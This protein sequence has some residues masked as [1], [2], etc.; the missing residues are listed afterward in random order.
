MTD[1]NLLKLLHENCDVRVGKNSIIELNIAHWITKS[2]IH[3]KSAE[4]IV[5]TRA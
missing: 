5:E 3:K 1:L 4:K 2:L